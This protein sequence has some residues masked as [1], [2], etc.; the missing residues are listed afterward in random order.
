MMPLALA[1]Q[2]Q[3]VYINKINGKDDTRKILTNLGFTVGSEVTVISELGGNMILK[4]K[5]T[6]VALD[7][8]MAQ[9]IIVSQ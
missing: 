9:R 7:K 2:G 3:T 4:V 6:R 1:D 8:K 5:E